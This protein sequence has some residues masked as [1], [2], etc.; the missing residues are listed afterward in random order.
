MTWSCVLR[1]C[2]FY[3]LLSMLLFDIHMNKIKYKLQ[4]VLARLEELIQFTLGIA[5]HIDHTGGQSFHE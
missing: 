4:Y 5:D 2:A 1:L 3:S